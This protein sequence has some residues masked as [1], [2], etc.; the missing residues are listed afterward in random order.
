MSKWRKKKTGMIEHPGIRERI[1]DVCIYL[2][3]ILCMLICIIPL[4]HT[5]MA[6]LSDGQLLAA[7]TGVLQKWITADGTP[8]W[9]GYLK[10]LQYS[11]HAILKSYLITILYVIA[12]VLCGLIINVTGAYVLYRK[13]KAAPALTIFIIISM[14]FNGGTVPT[15]M[16]I[17][18]L[19]MTGT[20]WSLIIPSC[21]NAM[22]LIMVL[23]GFKQV[24]D[25][26]IESAELDGAGHFTIMFRILLPQ[27]K[28][29]TLVTVINQAILTWNSWFEAS[30]YVPN[31]KELWP[32]QLWI[33]QVVA[34]NADIMSASTPDWNKYLV[35]YCVILIAT[36][37]VLLIMPFVQKQLQKGALLGAVKG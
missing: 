34:D 28:G 11:D 27:A 32:L 1:G 29:L 5:L 13:P 24:P 37:P 22:F 17:K 8:N 6:S 7:H 3:L 9:S 23:N 10:T 2:F 18:S 33:R 26:T 16:V 4:W 31:N 12:N 20:A 36:V 35:S 30:I 21:T 15:Y 25:S 14:M 19:G